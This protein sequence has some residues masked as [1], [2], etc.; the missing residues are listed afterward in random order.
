MISRRTKRIVDSVIWLVLA[1]PW[2]V[3]VFNQDPLWKLLCLLSLLLTGWWIT[4]NRILSKL[5]IH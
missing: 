4:V 5:I 1:S 3:L 2:I